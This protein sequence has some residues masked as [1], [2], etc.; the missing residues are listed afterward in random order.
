MSTSPNQE[1][2][3][4]ALETLDKLAAAP[5]DDSLDVLC[6]QAGVEDSDVDFVAKFARSFEQASGL[7]TEDLVKRALRRFVKDRD[8]DAILKG[9]KN[10]TDND[11]IKCAAVCRLIDQQDLTDLPEDAALLASLEKQ[12]VGGAGRAVGTAITKYAPR[13][14]GGASRGAGAVGGGGGRP[15]IDASFRVLDKGARSGGMMRGLGKL[16]P[17]LAVGG[18][19]YGGAKGGEHLYNTYGAPAGKRQMME[20]FGPMMAQGFS[21][22][23][24]PQAIVQ[25]MRQM[26]DNYDPQMLDM[27]ERAMSFRRNPWVPSYWS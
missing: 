13:I 5:S 24:N 18:G 20:Q 3:S 10:A 19:V 26:G 21:R 4:N 22:G 25:M 27:L 16:I 2:A 11:Q 6:K 23:G 8:T 12:A 9:I 14:F 7:S 17:G 1:A 15:V